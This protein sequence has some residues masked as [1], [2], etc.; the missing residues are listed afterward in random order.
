[1][2][3][4]PIRATHVRPPMSSIAIKGYK[5]TYVENSKGGHHEPSVITHAIPNHR[6][7]HFVKC[8]RVL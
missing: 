1:V 3:T 8:N 5:S 6:N 2:F 4:N 7:A